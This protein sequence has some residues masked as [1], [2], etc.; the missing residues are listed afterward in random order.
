MDIDDIK[1]ELNGQPQ[2]NEPGP[3]HPNW[4]QLIAQH[5]RTIACYKRRL[6]AVAYDLEIERR[7]NRALRRLNRLLGKENTEL[8][9][10]LD[11]N[12]NVEIIRAEI[13]I[14]KAN[15]EATPF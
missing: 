8:L 15:S 6:E 7:E 9:E 1:V 3:L 4:A 11:W 10:A 2:G 14:E 12:E 5:N 13:Q